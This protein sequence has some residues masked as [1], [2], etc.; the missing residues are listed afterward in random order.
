[1]KISTGVS[2]QAEGVQCVASPCVV[3]DLDGTLICGNSL[4]MLVRFMAAQLRRRRGFWRLLRMG[5]LLGL[6]RLRL[7]SHTG[8]KHPVHR[9]AAESMSE[10]DMENFVSVLGAA[11]NRK[12]LERLDGY[13]RRGYRIL[14]AS[15]APDLYL[16]RLTALTGFD[17]F[18]AT[19]LP[20]SAGEAYTETRGEHKRDLC[21][22]YAAREGWTIAVVATDHPDDL[23]LLLLPGISRLLVSPAPGLPEELRRRGLDFEII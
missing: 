19:P 20:A 21:L 2:L 16:P 14:L 17:G 22:D 5:G 12:L 1:M 13:R 15:A 10:A 7:I 9:M 23:P 4:H 8:M 6:R 3:V 11:L 18:I